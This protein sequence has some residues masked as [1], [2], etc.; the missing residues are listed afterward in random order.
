M[1]PGKSY[2]PEDFLLMA[3]RRKWIIAI[4]PIVFGIATTMWTQSLP[5]R[6]QSEATIL[7]VPPRVSEKIVDQTMNTT[8]AERL[9]GLQQRLM[10]RSNLERIIQELNLYP[11]ERKTMLMEQV[12]DRMGHDRGDHRLRH[13]RDVPDLHPDPCRRLPRPAR[14]DRGPGPPHVEIKIADPGTGAVMATGETGEFVPAATR[15]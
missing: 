1:I 15:S 8:L 13:D 10:S 14:V 9:Q 7:V 5:N 11:E 12:V 4:P 6:Y 3:W 2:K